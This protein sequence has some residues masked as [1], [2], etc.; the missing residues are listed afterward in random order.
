MN[1]KMEKRRRVT[2]RPGDAD[3]E[4]DEGD[5]SPNVVHTLDE[6]PSFC[7]LYNLAIILY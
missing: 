5:A 3:I 2:E 6:T 7:P 1:S 4:K